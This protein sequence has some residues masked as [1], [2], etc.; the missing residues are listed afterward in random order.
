VAS[1]PISESAVTAGVKSA[2]A[3]NLIPRAPRATLLLS[4]IAESRLKRETIKYTFLLQNFIFGLL[5][6]PIYFRLKSVFRV[7]DHIFACFFSVGKTKKFLI[8]N[9]V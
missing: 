9:S 4:A 5:L 1:T 6:A 7:L 2:P 8:Q 3:C